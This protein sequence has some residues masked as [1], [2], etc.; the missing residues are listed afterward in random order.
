[1]E[2]LKVT[3]MLFWVG[4]VGYMVGSVIENTLLWDD[5][6]YYEQKLE[7]PIAKVCGSVK[8][9]ALKE[10]HLD[11]REYIFDCYKRE[12]MIYNINLDTL[13]VTEEKLNDK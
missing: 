6:E 12:G 2:G 1:M 4:V 11:S 9:I 3:F 10:Y 5:Q 13:E 8:Y 7:V